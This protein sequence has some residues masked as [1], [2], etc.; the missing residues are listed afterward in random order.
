MVFE[1][2]ILVESFRLIYRFIYHGGKIWMNRS[3]QQRVKW[4]YHQYG[5]TREEIIEYIKWKYKGQRKHRKFKPEKSCLETYVLNFTYYA[6][7][8]L[9]RQC[10]NHES[11]GK[12]EIP[13]SQLSKYEPIKRMGNSIESYERQGIEGLIDDK[14][15]E[16]VMI[17]KELMQMALEFFGEDDLYAI[18]GF[19]KKRDEAIKLNL[20]YDAYRNR[21]QRK[22][23]MF[24]SILKDQGYDLD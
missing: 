11:G 16:D 4:L 20:T 12:S 14:S 17:G 13:F 23:A 3:I 2:E 8:S 7:L 18:I 1:N 19:K 15:P 6:L 21:L 24:R 10:K 9:V 22:M 5:M